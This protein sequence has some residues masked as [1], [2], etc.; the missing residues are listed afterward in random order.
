M[1]RLD[2]KDKHTL[3]TLKKSVPDPVP[4]PGSYIGFVI[5]ERLIIFDRTSRTQISSGPP[6]LSTLEL[7]FDLICI[8]PLVPRNAEDIWLATDLAILYVTLASPG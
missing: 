8:L 7:R 5:G 4:D 3:T 1:D 6:D 2:G